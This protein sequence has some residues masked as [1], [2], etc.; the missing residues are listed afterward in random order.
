M[1]GEAI[2]NDITGARGTPLI[3]R[4]NAAGAKGAKR[5]HHR[6]QHDGCHWFGSKGPFDELRGPGHLNRHRQRNR[7]HQIGPDVHKGF[8]DKIADPYDL[9]KKHNTYLS[10]LIVFLR[11]LVPK[12]IPFEIRTRIDTDFHRLLNHRNFTMIERKKFL[13][14]TSPKK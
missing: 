1:E 6:G 5:A 3:N 9:I 2:Q 11:Y 10:I 14:S 7:H 4:N 8:D 13:A 12:K